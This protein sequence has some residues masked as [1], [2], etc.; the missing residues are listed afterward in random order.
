LTVEPDNI[1]YNPYEIKLSDILEVWEYVAH[2][3][4]GDKK[5][6]QM[7][8]DP[9]DIKEMFFELKREISKLKR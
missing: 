5:Q 6:K 8:S 9:D 7:T 3:E 1:I 2:I 4:R